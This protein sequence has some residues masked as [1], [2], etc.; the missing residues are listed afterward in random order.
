MIELFDDDHDVRLLPYIPKAPA[1]TGAFYFFN[2]TKRTHK[3]IQ[4]LAPSQRIQLIYPPSIEVQ[5]T[6]DNSRISQSTAKPSLFL[7]LLP[8]PTLI[9]STHSPTTSFTIAITNDIELSKQA[10][11]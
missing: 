6:T 11:N 7:F 8:K 4:Y 3:R 1:T 9:A 2:N 5:S 10:A